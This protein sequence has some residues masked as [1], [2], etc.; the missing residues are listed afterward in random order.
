MRS[1]L[2]IIKENKALAPETCTRLLPSLLL[3]ALPSQH[4]MVAWKGLSDTSWRRSESDS[5]ISD[6]SDTDSASVRHIPRLQSQA[7]LK[8]CSLNLFAELA[9]DLAVLL[10][11]T[12]YSRLISD[13]RNDIVYSLWTLM[14]HKD[15]FVSASVADCISAMLIGTIAQ[16]IERFRH[17]PDPATR[18]AVVKVLEQFSNSL[19]NNAL[20]LDMIPHGWWDSVLPIITDQFAVDRMFAI[21]SMAAN[22]IAQLS[23][24]QIA[25]LKKTSRTVIWSTV[26]VLAADDNAEEHSILI[27]IADLIVSSTQDSKVAVKV[28]AAWALG[29]LA[30]AL[31]CDSTK[32]A[33]L[34]VDYKTQL[35]EAAIH[36]TDDNEKCRAN[37]VRAIGAIVKL[38]ATGP[39][40]E[41]ATWT[42]LIDKAIQLA[43]KSSSTGSFKV[44]TLAILGISVVFTD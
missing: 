37:G 23:E 44:T 28:R 26:L 6:F 3:F 4:E 40:I 25:S 15:S 18:L 10:K 32:L 39:P 12:P 35:F 24:Y 2:I 5:E 7:K 27:S 22:A 29:N 43:V 33:Q 8:I 21:R 34:G 41:K 30:H 11:S 14:N 9:K 31:M 19:N 36:F 16:N 13:H 42:R 1:I 38:I 20:P 17:S